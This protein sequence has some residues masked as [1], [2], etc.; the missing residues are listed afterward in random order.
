MYIPIALCL[1]ASAAFAQQ[2]LE[3]QDRVEK[4]EDAAR[5]SSRQH[6]RSDRHQKPE[7]PC[8]QKP[9][10]PCHQKPDKPDK[11]DRHP[12]PC[13]YRQVKLK[14]NAGYYAF[15]FHLVGEP[16]RD[17]FHFNYGKPTV[18]SVFDCYC[19]GDAFEVFDSNNY[20]GYTEGTN[21]GNGTCVKY[22][23]DP[24]VCYSDD[25][26]SFLYTPLNPGRHNLTLS[27]WASPYRKGTA[28]LRIDDLC[29][30]TP[31]PTG[32]IDLADEAKAEE[33]NEAEAE[34]ENQQ[35]GFTRCCEQTFSCSQRIV[36]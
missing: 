35:V 15:N 36:N 27:P 26:W 2:S 23:E 31:P 1:I 19:T 10:K 24:V 6:H 16:V 8:H 22:S 34:D 12:K 3:D 32:K 21:D 18:L 30:L 11:P 17:S 4:I 14:P 29:P 5:P 28:F 20:V 9:E 25:N 33:N 7:K 13:T